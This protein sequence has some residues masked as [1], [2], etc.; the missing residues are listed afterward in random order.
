MRLLKMMV[1]AAVGYALYEFIKGMSG[2]GGGGRGADWGNV[3]Y[4]RD[5]DR[6]LSEDTGR[7]MNMTG[8]G[9]GMSESTE[10]ASGASVPH[11]VGRGVVNP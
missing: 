2:T 8:P 11:L 7:S 10:D 5:L 3:G 6:A 1:Y 4:G 9:R